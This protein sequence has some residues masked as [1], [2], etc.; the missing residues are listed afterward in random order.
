MSYE[1]IGTGRFLGPRY[2]DRS[3]I[4]KIETLKTQCPM[5]FYNLVMHLMLGCHR[6]AVRATHCISDI[7]NTIVC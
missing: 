3:L 2:I 4:G 7:L 6:S 5:L 1:Y